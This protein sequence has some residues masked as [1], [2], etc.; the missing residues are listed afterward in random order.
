MFRLILLACLA[1]A[2]VFAQGGG[3]ASAYDAACGRCHDDPIALMDP[4]GLL[5]AANGAATLDAFL[6]SHKRSA[7][8]AAIRAEIVAYLMALH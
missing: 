4:T 5:G 2:P 8:D 3:G 6:A 7:S 1:A